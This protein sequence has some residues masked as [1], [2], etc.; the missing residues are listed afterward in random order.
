M[1]KKW[2]SFIKHAVSTGFDYRAAFSKLDTTFSDSIDKIDFESVIL[3]HDSRFQRVDASE[4]AIAFNDSGNVKYVELLQ[5]VA[6][7][8]GG[9]Y[10]Q[11]EEL[12][13]KKI[14]AKAKN[15]DKCGQ[16]FFVN[17]T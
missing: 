4:L 14:R 7:G 5:T 15:F 12:V 13:R 3:K 2:D 9:N 6:P 1:A 17:M 16:F 8:N 11:V 10:W